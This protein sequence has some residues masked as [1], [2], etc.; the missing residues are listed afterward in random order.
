MRREEERGEERRGEERRGEE[1]RGEERIEVEGRNREEGAV[2]VVLFHFPHSSI[3]NFHQRDS[4]HASACP[5][6][7]PP[8]LKGRLPLPLYD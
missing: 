4:T 6:S 5:R 1:K 8:S 3:T 7:A 2:Q